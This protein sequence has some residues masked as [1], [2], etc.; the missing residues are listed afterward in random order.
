M[1]QR[2]GVARGFTARLRSHRRHAAASAPDQLL[3]YIEV[4]ALSLTADVESVLRSSGARPAST[5]GSPRPLLAERLGVVTPSDRRRSTRPGANPD[6]SRT[7]ERGAGRSHRTTVCSRSPPAWGDAVDASPVREH[8]PLKPRR[9]TRQLLDGALVGGER[10]AAR[11]RAVTADR[12]QT[13]TRIHR[14]AVR[15]RRPST[16]S[17]SEDVAGR[18]AGTAAL[19]ERIWTSCYDDVDD[20]LDRLGAPAERRLFPRC[21][22][23]RRSCPSFRTPPTLRQIADPHLE[24][25]AGRPRPAVSPAPG[26]RPSVTLDLA[27]APTVRA[28]RPAR[29]SVD[30]RST[31]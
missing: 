10:L 13:P 9:A 15:C 7:L 24:T 17:S 29:S 4:Y 1:G 27:R 28:R 26:R 20:N 25:H 19:H 8:P 2:A 5:P 6:A 14:A 22:D 18:P 12:D 3:L 21:G 23:R 31:T 16:S 11:R 30:V